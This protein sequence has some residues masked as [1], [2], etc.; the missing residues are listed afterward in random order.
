M[1]D[2]EQL[3]A[4]YYAKQEEVLKEAS[5][6]LKE[7]GAPPQSQEA[8]SM[9][10]DRL[11]AWIFEVLQN[12]S[13]ISG[14]LESTLQQTRDALIKAQERME[15]LEKENKEA[16]TTLL[17]LKVREETE[18]L[19]PG[20]A[21]DLR[22]KLREQE[23]LLRKRETDLAA[24]R[25]QFDD[26]RREM[27]SLVLRLQ[28]QEEKRKKDSEL[29]D[30]QSKLAAAE[31]ALKEAE[32]RSQAE[33][34]KATRSANEIVQSTQK[35]AEQE[36]VELNKLRIYVE[37]LQGQVKARDAELEAARAQAA[38]LD[39]R[40]EELEKAIETLR[41]EKKDGKPDAASAEEIER[42]RK[43][44]A[45]LESQLGQPEPAVEEMRKQL[46]EANLFRDA[47]MQRIRA[48]EVARAQDAMA[49]KRPSG[50]S[51]EEAKAG[52]F[53]WQ[54][55]KK[56]FEE[57]LLIMTRDLAHLQRTHENSERVWIETMTRQDT[58]R[59][60]QIAALKAE[61]Q[62]LRMESAQA[63]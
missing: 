58:S 44:L 2:Y 28:A 54:T 3:A 53:K 63:S 42:L 61:I 24:L 11:R 27:E 49:A 14:D 13:Q 56:D 38:S 41:S 32:S 51:A 40:R 37:E 52:E 26:S 47:L 7:A 46:S 12:R 22:K 48:L 18:G 15:G 39:K 1:S 6:R 31:K 50:M 16:S 29:S 30:F 60:N 36:K 57:R 10:A 19:A 5:Q 8:L 35:T 25:R 34:E 4:E 20:P 9:A 23:E 33:L 59:L 55:E 62:R 45:E 21:A 17:A 43:R